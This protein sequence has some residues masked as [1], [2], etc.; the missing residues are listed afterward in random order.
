MKKLLLLVV[1]L[2]ILAGFWIALS[3]K[4]KVAP[5]DDALIKTVVE[6][7][8]SIGELYRGPEVNVDRTELAYTRSMSE[9][10]GMSMVNLQTGA[11]E[12]FLHTNQILRVF[13]YSPDG[14]YLLFRDLNKGVSERLV[15]RDRI[16][17][18]LIPI[19]ENKGNLTQILWLTTN[20]LAVAY[21]KGEETFICRI[22]LTNQQQVVQRVKNK[23]WVA[24]LTGF[25]SNAVA[26]IDFGN[27][28]KLDFDTE[29]RTQ[30]SKLTK[31]D[32]KSNKGAKKLLASDFM[33]LNYQPGNDRFL[34]CSSDESN[35][36]HLFHFDPSSN[37]VE[38]LIFDNEHSY[39]GKW[40]Q[41]G[42]GFAYVGNL[43]NHFYLAIRP[44]NAN[45]STNLFFGGHVYGFTVSSDGSKI[46]AAASM[47][48]EP[49]EIWEYDI[50]SRE[51]RQITHRA[52]LK[53]AQ[54]IPR[55]EQWVASF[56]GLKIPSFVL[57]PRD[58]DKRKK[59]PAV[60]ST[61]PD[62]N[63][64]YDAWENYSQFLGNIGCYHFAVNHRGIDGYG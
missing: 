57:P 55:Q 33:W 19:Q 29:E 41:K 39:N 42:K 10:R 18:T 50:E 53:A 43:T 15:L 3:L 31:A 38:Q 52:K 17:G 49:P 28:W 11:E 61:P 35:G 63:Q 5:P 20:T 27:I 25:S 51:L 6:E 7:I 16:N 34:F 9:G 4:T 48:K 58:L 21:K 40:I 46:F 64:F 2:I 47:K 44:D 23:N 12:R 45:V 1:C 8:M 62:G 54:I 32:M 26:Y 14:R 59:Y 56:D 13:D 60:I 24:A 22:A 30:L 37:Q 36:R